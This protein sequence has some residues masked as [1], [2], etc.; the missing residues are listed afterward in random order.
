VAANSTFSAVVVTGLE[1]LFYNSGT[2][3]IQPVNHDRDLKQLIIVLKMSA[4]S[5]TLERKNYFTVEKRD[6]PKF[7][8]VKGIAKETPE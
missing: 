2:R 1:F 7:P 6:F 3:I 8:W 4:S 5:N